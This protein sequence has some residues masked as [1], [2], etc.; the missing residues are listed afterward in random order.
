MP[1]DFHKLKTISVANGEV[2]LRIPERWGVFPHERVEGC[3]GCYEEEVEGQDTDTGTLWIQVDH[4]LWQGE[5]EPPGGFGSRA[6]AEAIRADSLP[7]LP[8]LLA[9]EIMEVEQGHRW[10]RVYDVEEDGDMIRFWFSHFFLV[11]PGHVATVSINFVLA[12]YRLDDPEFVE[13]W[14]IMEREISAAFLDPFKIDEEEEAEEALGSLHRCNFDDRV[15]LVLPEVMRGWPYEGEDGTLDN[16]WYFRLEMKDSHAGL[17]VTFDDEEFAFEEDTSQ[18]GDASEFREGNET[19][20]EELS[21]IMLER[22]FQRVLDRWTDPSEG[23]A[24][25]RRLPWGMVV[26]DVSDDENET[27]EIDLDGDRHDSRP[28]RNHLWRVM[29]H[30]GMRNRR[31]QVLLMIPIEECEKSPYPELVAYMDRAVRR[32]EFPGFPAVE[33]H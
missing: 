12:H 30:D 13:L 1:F 22:V 6:F 14:E 5:G 2:T 3:W 11:R 15:K 10:Y 9:D 7:D 24:R 23:E 21:R 31:L 17:F 4:H 26:Y 29:C 25:G 19:A 28:L 32:A 16:C 27:A 8:P 20:D 33:R 18:S